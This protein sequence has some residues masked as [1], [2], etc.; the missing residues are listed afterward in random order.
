MS[1]NAFPIS[2]PV[3]IIDVGDVF[4]EPQGTVNIHPTGGHVSISGDYITFN[5]KTIKDFVTT[6]AGDIIYG[7]NATDLARLGIGTAGQFLSVV[8]GLPSWVT[9]AS[10]G[11]LGSAISTGDAGTTFAANTAWTTL[12]SDITSFDVTSAGGVADDAFHFTGGYFE[13]PATG[14]YEFCAS[15]VYDANNSCG[16]ATIIAP[17]IG[18]CVRQIRLAATG[19]ASV[20]AAASV[21]AEPYNG[22]PTRVSIENC[23]IA[24]VPNDIV[25]LDGRHDA[26]VALGV[27]GASGQSYFSVSRVR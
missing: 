15:I 27:V 3:K 23:K 6:T 26:S 21:Q 25:N 20:Y 12:T 17:P 22:N 5:D 10:Q 11:P 13:C 4:I 2:A 7:A 14:V 18:T 16:G 9:L 19:G 8:G 24:L 1:G